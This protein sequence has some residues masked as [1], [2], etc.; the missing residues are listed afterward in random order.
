M[1]KSLVSRITLP[2]NSDTTIVTSRTYRGIST[3]A[4][5]N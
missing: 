5:G 3:I 1:E 4:D 2:A